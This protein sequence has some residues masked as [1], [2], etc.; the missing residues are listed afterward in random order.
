VDNILENL[1]EILLTMLLVSD[2]IVTEQQRKGQRTMFVIEM[3][4][5]GQWEFIAE[6]ETEQH[7]ENVKRRLETNWDEIVRIEFYPVNVPE[8]TF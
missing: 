4:V 6:Y 3:I 7:A 5:D 1:L 8:L 2:M